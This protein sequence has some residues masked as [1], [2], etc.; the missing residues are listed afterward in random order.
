[1]YI[2]FRGPGN[3]SNKRYIQKMPISQYANNWHHY[4][5]TRDQVSGSIKLYIDGRDQNLPMKVYPGDPGNNFESSGEI[6]IGKLKENQ[7]YFKGSL[8]KLKMFRSVKSINEIKQSA[9][10]PNPNE[11]CPKD[12][13]L[14]IPMNA[15]NKYIYYK[16]NVDNFTQM[17]KPGQH[18]E[19]NS[20]PGTGFTR[21]GKVRGLDECKQKCMN[22]KDCKY[23]NYMGG[24]NPKN[25]DIFTGK[26]NLVDP[27][28]RWW[29]GEHQVWE[30]KDGNTAENCSNY[31]QVSTTNTSIAKVLRKY[32]YTPSTISLWAKI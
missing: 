1:M 25:C 29:Y 7:W 11:P 23:I 26:C 5:I 28:R 24:Y 14:Y 3:S 12:A 15:N 10:N 27:G 21:L 31:I 32:R 9:S 16:K 6:N 19:C 2:G 17:T 30:K 4:A 22:I 8:K 20:G 18:L 13:I